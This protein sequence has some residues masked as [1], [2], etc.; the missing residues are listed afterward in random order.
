MTNNTP[1]KEQQTLAWNLIRCRAAALDWAPPVSGDE[2][3]RLLA[4]MPAHGS[5]EPLGNWLRRGFGLPAEPVAAES[6]P[7]A[8][9]LAFLRPPRGTFQPLGQ[10]LAWAAAPPGEGL[11]Q[12]PARVE[13]GPGRFRVVFE[14]L[15]D[16]IRVKLEALGFTLARLAGR[17]V[18]VC[19]P[20]GLDQL[21]ALVT[22][23]ARGEAVFELPDDAEMR[24]LLLQVQLG[25]IGPE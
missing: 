5:E 22:L 3:G 20:Q 16:R 23:D 6:R 24:R 17:E 19:G 15:E 14:V 10:V 13:I 2:I 8:Q 11:P 18:A 1:T 12:L 4:Q 25:E 9:V 7:V 21:L